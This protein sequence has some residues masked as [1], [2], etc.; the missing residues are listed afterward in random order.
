MLENG[1]D[2][3]PPPLVCDGFCCYLIEIRKYDYREK[4]VVVVRR[5]VRFHFHEAIEVIEKANK[6][7][8]LTDFVL[9]VRPA[10]WSVRMEAPADEVAAWVGDGWS[11]PA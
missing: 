1:S 4:R 9:S 8:E 6:D 5:E 7:P 11:L 3:F 10:P 2:D